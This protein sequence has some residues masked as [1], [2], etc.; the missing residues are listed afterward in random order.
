MIAN[1][2][3][4]SVD[5]RGT[6]KVESNQPNGNAESEFEEK[7]AVAD[8]DSM[9]AEDFI[10][11]EDEVSSLTLHT[12]RKSTVVLFCMCCLLAAIWAIMGIGPDLNS[13]IPVLSRHPDAVWTKTTIAIDKYVPTEFTDLLL[14][15]KEPFNLDIAQHEIRI[16]NVQ[17]VD[18]DGDSQLDVLVCNAAQNTVIAYHYRGSEKIGFSELTDSDPDAMNE[19]MQQGAVSSS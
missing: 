15:D 16:T 7:T 2:V 3:Y 13:E 11:P 9:D 17:V 19:V 6:D 8:D 18:I 1:L 14:V 12:P 4:L 5:E 10:E